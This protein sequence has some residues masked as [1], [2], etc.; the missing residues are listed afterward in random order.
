MIGQRKDTKKIK[1]EK[2]FPEQYDWLC[3]VCGEWCRY[4][5]I[6]CSYCRWE[7]KQQGGNDYED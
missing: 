4:F 5:E 2:A 6:T 3:P 1:K 7:A